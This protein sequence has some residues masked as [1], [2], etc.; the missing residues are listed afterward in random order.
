[1]DFVLPVNHKVKIKENKKIDKY[2][3][4]TRELK[5]VMKHEG[6]SD[7]SH[8]YSSWNDPQI[9]GKET[10]RTGDQKKTIQTG[11]LRRVLETCCH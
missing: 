3:D 5:K 1:M 6:D 11:I 8:S 9:P 10:G 2:L 7:S 4:L